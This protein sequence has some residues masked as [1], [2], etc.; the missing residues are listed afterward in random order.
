M[1]QL[2]LVQSG[3]VQAHLE[4]KLMTLSDRRITPLLKRAHSADRLIFKEERVYSD[5]Y[6]K[7]YIVKSTRLWNRLQEDIKSI[8]DIDHFKVRVKQEMFLNNLNFSE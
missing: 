1:P 2:K 3:V 6:K 7:S 4:N 8:V 5:K